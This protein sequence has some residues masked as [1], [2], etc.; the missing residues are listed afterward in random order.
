MNSHIGSAHPPPVAPPLYV[1]AEPSL[2]NRERLILQLLSEGA[3]N[4][5]AARTLGVSPETIKSHMKNI[6]GKLS[7]D[8]RAQA[9]YKAHLYGL[10]SS[11]RA[12]W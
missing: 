9:V 12:P 2:S 4:K 6:F 8:K 1:A 10:L 11:S 5:Q 3:S 7:V